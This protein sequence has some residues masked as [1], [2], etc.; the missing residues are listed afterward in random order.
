MQTVKVIKKSNNENPKYETSQ[1]A[2]MDLR[3]SFKYVTPENPIKVKGDTETIYKGESHPVT[4]LRLEPK[5]RAI[6]PTDLY[7][8]VPEGHF[9]A[10]FPRSGLSFKSAVTLNNCVGVIDSDY[11]GNVGISVVNNGFETV[12]IEDGERIA[13]LILLPYVKFN[14]ENVDSLDKT[15]RNPEG[16]GTTGLH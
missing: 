11:T 10:I 7:I 16:F 14:W 2:G 6:I 13:Q 8:K 12:W 5:A 1:A 9:A 4:M 3:A 15:D